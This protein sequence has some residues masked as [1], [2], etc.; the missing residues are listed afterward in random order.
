MKL[1]DLSN[2]H[3]HY[4]LPQG[5]RPLDA[6]SALVVAFPAIGFTVSFEVRVVLVNIDI[7]HEAKE[8]GDAR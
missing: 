7:G 4:F 5:F 8:F 2:M 6:S 3:A 1:A